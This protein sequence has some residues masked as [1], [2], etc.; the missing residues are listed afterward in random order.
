[1]AVGILY[2][3]QFYNNYKKTKTR[4]MFDYS[5]HGMQQPFFNNTMLACFWQQD[6]TNQKLQQMKN[7]KINNYL[8][9]KK[10]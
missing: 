9:K 2:S 1:M 8:R 4:N 10:A 3:E 7:Y 5:E 6:K